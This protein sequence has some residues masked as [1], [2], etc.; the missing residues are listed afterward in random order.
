M[1]EYYD[2]PVVKKL[3]R[4]MEKQAIDIEKPKK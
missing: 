3:L 2:T 4:A 1:N